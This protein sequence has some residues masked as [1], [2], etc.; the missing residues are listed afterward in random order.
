ML[1]CKY[2]TSNTNINL[3]ENDIGKDLYDRL[4]S[5]EK[6]IDGKINL[7]SIADKSLDS[8]IESLS[9]NRDVSGLEQVS[10]LKLML[11]KQ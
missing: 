8:Q 9:T 1:D 7:E 2:N 4:I 3:K 5:L 10:K 6:R 11:K